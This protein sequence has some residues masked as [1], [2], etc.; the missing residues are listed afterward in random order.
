VRFDRAVFDETLAFLPRG[1]IDGTLQ[2]LR[3]RK[4]DMAQLLSMQAAPAML[5]EAAH[6]LA[7]TAGM[8]G[9]MALSAV[10]RRY[11]NAV[12]QDAP[13]AEALAVQVGTEARATIAVLDKLRRERRLI[14][15]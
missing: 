3:D 2:A 8:F 1:D 14:A 6:A 15:A 12:A 5:T 7:S 13:E 4:E 11:E 9:F 10:A